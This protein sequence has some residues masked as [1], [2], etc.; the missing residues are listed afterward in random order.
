MSLNSFCIDALFKASISI[1]TSTRRLKD[2]NFTIL[3]SNSFDLLLLLTAKK[4]KKTCQIKSKH[5]IYMA[6]RIYFE[7]T[8][9]NTC[10]FVNHKS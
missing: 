9:E 5:Y 10:Y 1:A 4:P 2:F 3:N 7:K 8:R 6:F